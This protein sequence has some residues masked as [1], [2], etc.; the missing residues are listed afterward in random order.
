MAYLTRY[1]STRPHWHHPQRL[2]LRRLT[3]SYSFALYWPIQSP[4][5]ARFFFSGIKTL[6]LL[7]LVYR[8]SL[9]ITGP[10]TG[11]PLGIVSYALTG[12]Y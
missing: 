1:V 12:W 8:P 9:L 5:L 7:L 2:L 3:L 10:L 6:L 4:H 11:E